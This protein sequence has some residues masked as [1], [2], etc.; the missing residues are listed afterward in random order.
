MVESVVS[1]VLRLTGGVA[2]RFGD[3]QVG[4]RS[5]VLIV[6]PHCPHVEQLALL[7]QDEAEHDQ[8]DPAHRG[9]ETDQHPLYDGLVELPRL[10][11]QA[12]A[13]VEV[14]GRGE[15]GVVPLQPGVAALLLIFCLST[16]I[17]SRLVVRLVGVGNFKTEVRP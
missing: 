1:L 4:G 7:D 5:H 2:G 9:E 6:S 13:G 11:P 8:H 14:V 16:R 12:G 10:L 3:L 17:T 15:G